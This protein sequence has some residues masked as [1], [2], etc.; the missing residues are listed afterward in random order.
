MSI[1]KNFKANGQLHTPYQK[2]HQA[3]DDRI[4]SA[5]QRAHVMSIFSFL[6]AIIAI[7]SSSSALFLIKKPKIIPYII[8]LDYKG[9]PI[10]YGRMLETTYNY[11]P[12]LVTIRYHINQFVINFREIS[13]DI[14]VIKKNGRNAYNMV[15]PRGAAILTKY[16]RN[17]NPL[18]MYT[19]ITRDVKF[20]NFLEISNNSYTATWKEITY[21]LA[22]EEIN[23][24]TFRGT[25][26]ITIKKD[27]TE[28][29]LFKNPASLYIDTFVFAKDIK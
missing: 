28:E 18:K 16:L 10:N 8:E 27:I 26:V 22:G 20:I 7:I 13:S 14:V 17:E 12:T 24:S 5:S 19:D 9:K 21:N 11:T 6:C 1:T 25:F 3:W 23:D 4:G 29:E 15:T 2:A